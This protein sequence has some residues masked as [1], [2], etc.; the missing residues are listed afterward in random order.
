MNLKFT[1]QFDNI[2][3]TGQTDENGHI[4]DMMEQVLFTSPGERVNRPDFGCGLLQLVFQPNSSELAITT[5]YLVQGSLNRW[6]GDLI[7]VGEVEVIQ[8]DSVLQV[9]IVYTILR[10]QQRQLAQFTQ[11]NL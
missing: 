7:E 3:R 5:Q 6:L 4:R 8:E 9:T 2:G 11:N 10:T 1:L